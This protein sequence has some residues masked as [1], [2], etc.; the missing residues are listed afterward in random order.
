MNDT[1]GL[2]SDAS[3]LSASLQ[4]S[5]ESRL[6]A[7]MAAYGSP[8]YALT[9]KHW[10]MESGPR[11]C[12]LR[13]SVRRTSGNGS[14]GSLPE[15]EGWLTVQ[16]IDGAN[17][18]IGRALRYKGT[19]P[20]EQG[21][22]RNLD[23]KGSYRGDLKDWAMLL[24]GWQTVTANEDAAGQPGA[25][26]QL[27]LT[28]QAKHTQHGVDSKSFPGSMGKYAGLNPEFASWLMGY[29]DGVLQSR[30]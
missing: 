22:T 21:N 20:S 23:T 3:L 30:P 17:D 10:D 9:W 25:N 27:M 28:Q 6:Q 4:S 19:A 18:G 24:S 16:T 2:Y 8:E 13:A 29:P 5:L 1:S 7:R 15:F 14:T 12:A 26:M 11:I